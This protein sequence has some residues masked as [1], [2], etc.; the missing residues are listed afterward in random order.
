[1]QIAEDMEPD[2]QKVIFALVQ[3]IERANPT[4]D[5]VSS[6]NY[7]RHLNINHVS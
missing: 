1:M 7:L 5:G 2:K 4:N 6:I 3:Q